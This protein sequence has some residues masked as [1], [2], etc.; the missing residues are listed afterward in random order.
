MS[1]TTLKRAGD[2][3]SLKKLAETLDLANIA[4]IGNQ[5]REQDAH[6]A[7]ISWDA[8]YQLYPDTAVRE[9]ID[10]LRELR[11]S[12]L[13]YTERVTQ[14]TADTNTKLVQV[15]Q[16]YVG[17]N[18]KEYHPL[19]KYLPEPVQ[20]A[21]QT[22]Q[23]AYLAHLAE[24]SDTH[25]P[26]LILLSGYRSPA[27]QVLILF[28]YF[29]KQGIDQ[30]LK[31]TALPG[32]SEHNDPEWT[33]IDFTCIGDQDGNIQNKEQG[34]VVFEQYQE[35]DWLLE[36]APK[37]GFALTY[38]PDPANPRSG[39][40][41]DGFDYEPWHFRYLGDN[42]EDFMQDNNVRTIITERKCLL[43]DTIDLR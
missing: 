28:D 10:M 40:T 1:E 11:P 29:A 32:H 17:A 19:P 13:G 16:P 37:F 25:R 22:M 2:L 14:E 21:Y 7:T 6:I 36:H 23:T 27:Y 20:T 9:C 18:G 15:E 12:D 31:D 34:R 41:T 5:A 26:G 43:A 30:T 8:L 24:L 39:K 3:E 42:A 35:F 33:A 4:F 38:F